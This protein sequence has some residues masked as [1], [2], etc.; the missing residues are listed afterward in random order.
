VYNFT[1]FDAI[2]VL[3]TLLIIYNMSDSFFVRYQKFAPL[4]LRIGLAVVFVLF[5]IQ[6]LTSPGQTTAEI[7]LLSIFEL[8]DAAALNFYLGLTEIAIAIA[9]LIGFK[10][11]LFSFVA[12][13]FVTLLF[14][15]FIVKYGFS[16]NPDVYRDIGLLGASAA[17]FLLGAGPLSLD[18]R[19]GQKQ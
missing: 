3:I 17:L 11:R 9:F 14:A 12:S 1:I 5:G 19:S 13:G 18:N 6:K 2:I 10:V 15:S 16:V 8:A 4:C 7:Q